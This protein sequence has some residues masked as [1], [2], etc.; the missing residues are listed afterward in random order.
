M[1]PSVIPRGFLFSPVVVD[2]KIIGRSGQ[3]HGAR[4]VT[5]PDINAKNKSTFI[6]IIF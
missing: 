6:V 3:I 5:R 4:I 2:D 1:M